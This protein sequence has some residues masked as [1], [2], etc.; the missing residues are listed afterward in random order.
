[1]KPILYKTDSGKIVYQPYY[2]YDYVTVFNKTTN[3]YENRRR[4][5]GISFFEK[6]IILSM[7]L[8]SNLD[9][10]SKE[11]AREVVARKLRSTI[12]HLEIGKPVTRSNIFHTIEEFNFFCDNMGKTAH[13]F[14]TPHNISATVNQS[15]TTSNGNNKKRR[16]NTSYPSNEDNIASIYFHQDFVN[17]AWALYMKTFEETTAQS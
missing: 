15:Y 17:S 14:F 16:V 5:T 2:V 6:K 8:C 4:L 9:V 7:A 10:F 13:L 12:T 1:M 3:S 11:K